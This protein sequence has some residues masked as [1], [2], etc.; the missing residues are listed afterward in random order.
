MLELGSSC[1]SCST[2]QWFERMKKEMKFL[3]VLI[4]VAFLLAVFVVFPAMAQP[5]ACA[6]TYT[7][8]SGDYMR[9]IARYCDVTY[10]DLLKANPQIQNPDVIYPGEALNIPN[11][12]TT[13][14]GS[15]NTIPV[16]GSA[17]TA[18]VLVPVKSTVYVAQ[19]GVPTM[20]VT[21]ATGVIGSTVTITASGFQANQPV[22]IG[23][24][25]VGTTLY[26]LATATTDVNGA[27]IGQFQIPNWPDVDTRDGQYVFVIDQL[28]QPSLRAVAN[29]FIL[30][31][32]GNMGANLAPLSGGNSYYVVQQGD[33]LVGIA[34][35][36]H[37]SPDTLIALNPA[38]GSLGAVYP[39]EL[40]IL[41]LP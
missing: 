11:A 27:V 8:Q 9:L 33:T 3:L 18:Q 35:K 12:N 1:M 34:S 24:G 29:L 32:T 25:M 15:T 4:I 22:E 19:P 28:N 7:V 20:N 37:T 6:S 16:T 39:G 17:N 26:Q 23:F 21:P 38:I 10:S 31:G 36:F 40:I 5:A 30:T 2:W 41:P 13:Q 14:T